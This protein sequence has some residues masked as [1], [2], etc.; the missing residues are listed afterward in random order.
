MARKVDRRVRYTKMIL[1]NCLVELLNEKPLEKITVKEICE[2]AD[3]N[4]GT[5][6]SHFSDQYDLYNYM[7]DEIL[8][9][10]FNCL[11]DFMGKDSET[12]ISSLTGVFDYIKENAN[13]VRTLINNGV[14]Y[15][16]EKRICD[17]VRDMYLDKSEKCVDIY[18]INAIYSYIAAGAISIIRYWLNTDMEKSTVEMAEFSLKL[19]DTGL[20]SLL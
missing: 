1:R 8:E 19:A 10:T 9:N 4:R 17:V 12:L 2:K 15:S 11:G 14:E 20:S 5:F 3:V 16:T 13:T 7:V 6:Y 18:M